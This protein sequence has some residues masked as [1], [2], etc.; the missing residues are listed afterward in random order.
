M[1]WGV[2]P[3]YFVIVSFASAFE[4]LAHRILWSVPLLALLILV[5][6]QV[7]RLPR[8]TV[9][10]L[11]ACSVLLTAN[12]LTF[13]YGI[14]EGKIAET[15]LGYYLNPLLSVLLGAFI[16]GESMSRLQWVA[17]SVAA[18]GVAIEVLAVGYVPWIALVLAGSFA[19]YGLLRRQVAV[20]AALGLGIETVVL[21]P[22]ALIYLIASNVSVDRTDVEL[23]W[24]GLGGAVTVIPLLLFGAAASRLPLTV[25][26][27]FQY[28][29][30]T[31]SLAIAVLYYAEDITFGR[32]VS[33]AFVWLGIGLFVLDSL[34]RRTIT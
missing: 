28:L 26:G 13:I 16:L 5:G 17:T 10:T 1:F 9:L 4:V 27:N 19:I 6:K 29:G 24:L 31:L 12:W 7:Q 15:S 21:A 8:R 18:F 32:W 22:I 23:V 11:L 25:L 30:P 34:R 3:V 33:F 20:P 14:H 2:A